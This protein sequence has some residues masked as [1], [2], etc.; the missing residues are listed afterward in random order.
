M[1]NT[2][3]LVYFGYLDGECVFYY[4]VKTSGSIFFD[5]CKV[6]DLDDDEYYSHYIFC[7]ESARGYSF[8]F[9]ANYKIINE[10]I[11]KIFYI[12]IKPNN[13]PSL[14]NSL[15]SGYEIHSLL[16]V[17]NRLFFRKLNKRVLSKQEAKKYYV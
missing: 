12:Q 2:G 14:H 4:C 15:K 7:A 11:D 3:D 8:Q 17:R 9:Q 13:F 16:R 10:N 1:I 6:H 5:G